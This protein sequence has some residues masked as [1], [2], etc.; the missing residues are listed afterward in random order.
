MLSFGIPFA[1]LPLLRITADRDRMR[2]APTARVTLV[3]A[4][5]VIG[6]VI[7]LNLTL[8]VLTVAEAG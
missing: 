5:L 7:A 4:W 1:L 2:L 8:V 3:L 6:M